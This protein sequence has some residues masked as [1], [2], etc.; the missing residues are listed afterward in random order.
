MINNRFK[1][2]VQD[3]VVDC[4]NFRM[5]LRWIEFNK[6]ENYFTGKAVEYSRLGHIN[7]F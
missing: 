5:L 6:K 4:D 3:L 1:N 2:Y 7:F